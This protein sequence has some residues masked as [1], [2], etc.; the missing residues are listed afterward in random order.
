MSYP[1]DTPL[2]NKARK[3][4]VDGESIHDTILKQC[5]KFERQLN[6]LKGLDLSILDKTLQSLEEDYAHNGAEWSRELMEENADQRLAL[7]KI[8]AYLQAL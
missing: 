7:T 3:L 4:W 8:Y 6:E 2:T 1:K 5:E